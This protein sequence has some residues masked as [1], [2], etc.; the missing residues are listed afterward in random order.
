MTC[1]NCKYQWC[2]LCEEQ[3][4]YGH[5]DSGKCAGH[6]FTNADNLEEIPKVND[7]FLMDNQRLPDYFGLHKILPCYYERVP[8]FGRLY[9]MKFSFFIRYCI[10]L[11]FCLFGVIPI[12]LMKVFDFFDV[13]FTYDYDCTEILIYIIIVL[14][15][16]CLFVAYQIFLYAFYLLL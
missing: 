7:H 4:N 8:D 16:L 1:V 2:W 5:Y 6:Q 13:K 15:A 12:F 11:L 14:I 10:M 3:Y 9:I